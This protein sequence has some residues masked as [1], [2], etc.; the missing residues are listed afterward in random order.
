MR[1]LLFAFILLASCVLGAGWW[2]NSTN[3]TAQLSKIDIQISFDKSKCSDPRSPISILINNRT[4]GT[5]DNVRFAISATRPGFGSRIYTDYLTS[6]R[7]LPPN[8]EWTHCWALDG[9]AV[10]N[11][12]I[13]G[14]QPESLD[15]HATV[16]SATFK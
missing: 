10:R 3:E 5:I 12:T 16:S 1:L 14:N 8:A 2:V 9:Y 4:T 6:D 7:I 13:R 15:W 11:G